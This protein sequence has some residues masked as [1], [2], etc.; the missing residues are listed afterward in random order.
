MHGILTA[1][2]SGS[3]NLYVTIHTPLHPALFISLSQVSLFLSSSLYRVLLMY[4]VYPIRTRLVSIFYI[5]RVPMYIYVHK[6]THMQMHIPHAEAQNATRNRERRGR[7]ER[8]PDILHLAPLYSVCCLESS[9]CFFSP[10]SEITSQYH[11][12]DDFTR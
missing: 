7:A 8:A 1:C 6:F 2:I 9:F 11:R 10:F 4:S 3:I 12:S 5:A